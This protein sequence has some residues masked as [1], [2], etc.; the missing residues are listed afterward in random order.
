M[1]VR[2]LTISIS[3]S[4]STPLPDFVVAVFVSLRGVDVD[5]PVRQFV[6]LMC[7]GG[8]P[9]VHGAVVCTHN[10]TYVFIYC[11]LT[12]QSAAQGHLRAFH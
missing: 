7:L 4:D 8:H 5:D 10:A 9:I 3:L 11:R 12:A 6:T 1:L 2:T